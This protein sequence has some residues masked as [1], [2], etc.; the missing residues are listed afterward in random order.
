LLPPV[1]ATGEVPSTFSTSADDDAFVSSACACV[2]EI[3]MT[4]SIRSPRAFASLA[5]AS[6]SAAADGAKAR[7][8][9]TAMPPARVRART[10][11]ESDSERRRNTRGNL[12]RGERGPVRVP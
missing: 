7:P 2:P 10:L 1:L 4:G 3:W 11:R 5:G 6:E 12:R 8:A 9:V